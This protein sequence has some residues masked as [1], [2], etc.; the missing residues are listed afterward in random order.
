MTVSVAFVIALI[1]LVGAWVAN[2][3]GYRLKSHDVVV[4]AAGFWVLMLGGA[5]ILAQ[6]V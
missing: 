5:L 2:R 6:V 1:V 4:G 3:L